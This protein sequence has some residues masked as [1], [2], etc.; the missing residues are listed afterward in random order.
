MRPSFI[1]SGLAALLILF[2]IIA[3]Y[4]RQ[5]NTVIVLLLFSI[6][7]S[8]HSLM[9]FNEELYYGWNPLSGNMIPSDVPIR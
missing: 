7:L 3:A 1:G 9:H 2:A 5:Q 8:L 4:Q 6:A